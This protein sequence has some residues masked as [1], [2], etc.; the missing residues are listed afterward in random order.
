MPTTGGKTFV[1]HSTP[2]VEDEEVE[3]KAYL[4]LYQKGNELL[5]HY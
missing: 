1:T 3:H 2:A 4:D 5:D